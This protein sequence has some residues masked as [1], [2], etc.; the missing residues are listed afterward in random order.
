MPLKQR[1]PGTL[2]AVPYGSRQQ[3][4]GPVRPIPQ[5]PMTGQRPRGTNP[6]THPD[7]GTNRPEMGRGGRNARKVGSYGRTGQV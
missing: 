7:D 4:Q 1:A 3:P 5:P 6:H 2:Q